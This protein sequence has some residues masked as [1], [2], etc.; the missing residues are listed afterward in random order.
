MGQ[1][2]LVIKRRATIAH[3]EPTFKRVTIHIGGRVL[4]V[5]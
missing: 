4:V 2:L 1:G 3:V 5:S